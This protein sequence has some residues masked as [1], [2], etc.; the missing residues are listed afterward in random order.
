[1]R[2]LERAC[3]IG[4]NN[5]G[6]VGSSQP[7]QSG[8]PKWVHCEGYVIQHNFTSTTKREGGGDAAFAFTLL[9]KLVAFSI[10]IM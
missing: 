5:K 1:M 8:G 10:S 4:N 7:L 2:R 6:G 9:N 3:S